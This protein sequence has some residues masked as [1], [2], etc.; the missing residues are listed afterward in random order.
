MQPGGRR[1]PLC[2]SGNGAGH[3]VRHAGTFGAREKLTT[4]AFQTGPGNLEAE[5]EMRICHGNFRKGVTWDEHARA[6]QRF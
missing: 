2:V 6:E 5:S 3:P 4:S 1:V